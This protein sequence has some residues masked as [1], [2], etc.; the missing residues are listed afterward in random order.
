MHL[1][2]PSVRT[3]E[4]IHRRGFPDVSRNAA[5]LDVDQERQSTTMGTRQTTP[6]LA[7]ETEVVA[8]QTDRLPQRN[9]LLNQGQLREDQQ[10]T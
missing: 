9:Q 2:N 6:S 5:K 8:R 7:Q 10:I 4:T 3:Q 1:L